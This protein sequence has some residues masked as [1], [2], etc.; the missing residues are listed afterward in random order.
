MSEEYF[1]VEECKAYWW[2][3]ATRRK[4]NMVFGRLS[5]NSA[6]CTQGL[7][8]QPWGHDKYEGVAYQFD[9][10]CFQELWYWNIA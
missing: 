4:Y 2:D 10:E 6:H 8:T 9:T 7:R 3:I 5:C 1:H